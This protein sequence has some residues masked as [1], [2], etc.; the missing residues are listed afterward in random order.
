MSGAT[1]SHRITDGLRS[2]TCF[3][4]AHKSSQRNIARSGGGH[5]STLQ[6]GGQEAGGRQEFAIPGFSFS[7]VSVLAHYR[8]W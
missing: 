4:A 1:S 6:V 7:S 8:A 3:P 5:P 2:P